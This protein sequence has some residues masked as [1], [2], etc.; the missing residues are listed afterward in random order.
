MDKNI[1]WASDKHKAALEI[2]FR[3]LLFFNTHQCPWWVK[4]VVSATTW[5]FCV[6]E[7]L[8]YCN[9][10]I[11]CGLIV[12]RQGHGREVEEEDGRLFLVLSSFM[13]LPDRGSFSSWWKRE[14]SS[15]NGCT[16]E[17]GNFPAA[18]SWSFKDFAGVWL[19]AGSSSVPEPC[20]VLYAW[21]SAWRNGT[22][23]YKARI[24]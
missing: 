17:H 18:D 4:D 1:G 8:I 11:V 21:R 6:C 14:R 7:E 16:K 5:E 2:C 20:R 12:R 23:W 19:W 9:Y 13:S 15:G 24:I 3:L 10:C 22:F